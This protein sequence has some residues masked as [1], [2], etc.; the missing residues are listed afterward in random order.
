LNWIIPEVVERVQVIKGPYSAANGDFATGGAINLVTRQTDEQSQVALGGGSFDTYRTLAVVTPKGKSWRSLAAAEVYHTNGPFEHGED[1]NRYSV[2]LSGTRQ[3]EDGGKVTL[4]ATSYAAGWNAS[5]QIPGRAVES[6]LIG[7]FGSIDPGEGGSS[8]RHSLR[9]HYTRDLDQGSQVDVTAYAVDYRLQLF[10]NF[11]FFS[12]DPVRGDMIEQ[13]DRRLLTGVQARYWFPVY[14]GP[15]G[16]FAATQ[17]GVDLRNDVIDSG[18]FLAPGR[19]RLEAR[20][21][22]HVLEGSVGVFAQEDVTWTPWLRTVLGLR[23][24]YFGFDVEDRLE[25]SGPTSGT[26]GAGIVSPKA[27][28]VVTPSRNTEL[29][30]NFGMGYHSNDARGTVRSVD[31]VTSLTRATGAE[32]GFRSRLWDRVD[33]AMAGFWMDLEGETVWIGDEGTTE[34]SG[35][36]RRMGLELEAR[37]QILPW[38]Y[39]DADLNLVSARYL[40]EPASRN[41][42]P[43][44]PGRIGSAG[45]SWRHPSGWFGRIGLFHLGDRPANEDRS[46]TAV[47]FSRLD[48]SMGYRGERFEVMVAAQ[49]LTN[50]PIREAQFATVS[51]LPGETGAG[52][53]PAGTFAATD[54]SDSFAGC[55]EVNY[56]PGAPL[57][58]TATVRLFF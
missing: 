19:Q 46:L 49:N 35:P 25:P 38:L 55:E 15:N 8:Q 53:C 33:L 27:T 1:L 32:V 52:S 10:S 6:G 16:V 44:A 13:E 50:A 11:T 3:L 47:G 4:G 7:R 51:R 45:L 9:A 14:S 2:F 43:L 56:T 22:A 5:G 57:N 21:D 29:Y 34:V 40:E 37:Y 39:A 31:P 12:S 23:A 30:L 54:D 26:T 20:V 48:G 36:T 24:D 18:L 17:V 41:A 42:V 58:A 28:A